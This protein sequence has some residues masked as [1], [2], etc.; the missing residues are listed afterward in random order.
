M[1]HGNLPHLFA[2]YRKIGGVIDF[3]LFTDVGTLTEDVC[4]QAVSASIPELNRDRLRAISCRSVDDETFF[5]EWYDADKKVLIKRGAW[6][7]DDGRSLT[8]PLLTDLEGLRIVG[9]GVET[10]R[11]GAGGQFAYAFSNPPYGLRATPREVQRVF[12]EVRHYLLPPNTAH[13]ILD[14]SDPRLADAAEYFE[15]GMEWWG[16]FLFVVFVPDYRRLVVV[17][18]STTD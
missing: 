17:A 1:K 5:G 8:N 16:V 18:A 2:R 15:A 14:W 10:P 13:E 4:L 7:T 9:G 12:D 3:N 6:R 11:L